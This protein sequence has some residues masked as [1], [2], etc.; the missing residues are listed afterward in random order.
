MFRQSDL[1]RIKGDD[2]AAA[3]LVDASL[4]RGRQL[5]VVSAD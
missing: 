1:N 2:V 5:V 4:D 3:Q